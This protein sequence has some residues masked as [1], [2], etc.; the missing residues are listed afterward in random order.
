MAP[1]LALPE[2][3]VLPTVPEEATMQL[4]AETTMRASATDVLVREATPEDAERCARIF[5]DAFAAIARR[6]N[7]PVE[8]GSPEFTRFKVGDMLASDGVAGLVAERGGEVVGSAFVDERAV[9]AGIGPVTVDPAAQ[10]DG[11]GR[12][13]MRAVVWRERERGAVGMRLVQT[14]YHYRSLA[15]YAKLG[16]AVREPLSVLQGAP[17]ALSV[18]GLGVRA[19]REEDLAT[20]GDLCTRVHGHDRNRELLDAVGAGTARVVERPGRISGYATGF[21]YGWHAVAETNEDLIALLGS[22]ETFMGL[23]ILVPSRNAELLRWCLA[24]GLRVVQQ[25]TLMS[26]GLYNEPGGAWLPSIVY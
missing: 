9:V 5:Y 8:P 19:A 12:A 22:A 7:L 21:G 13:L 23:G 3:R 1:P 14:A 18:P 2:Y 26:T 4:Q 16:F 17:P 24:Q 25:S 10:D 20:C 15:L 11:V 6:H